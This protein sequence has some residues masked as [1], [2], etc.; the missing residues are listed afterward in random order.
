M[1]GR[2]ALT[3]PPDAVRAY[4]GYGDRPNFP[5]RYNIAPTQPIAI[6]R[7]DE[8]QR[9]FALAR[10][11]FLPAFV[12]DMKTFPLII[13][14]RSEGIA[15]KPS[16][17]SAI[18]RRRCLIPADGFYE[19]RRDG[20]RRLPYLIRRPGGGPLAFA[21]L[22]ETWHTAD[23]SE[24]DTACI[25]TSSA[26]GTISGLHERMPV[27]LEPPDFTPWLDP[28]SDAA[29]VLPLMR[30]AAEDALELV[31]VSS[32]VNSVANEGPDVQHPA[33]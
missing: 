5:P 17:R 12:K 33:V 1:C 25:I 6:V 13:N 20:K 28:H 15:D 9:R 16:F 26:N 14:A 10:W 11:G 30:P 27:I 21:G 22:W 32:A 2:Y 29:V 24:M 19:W 3:L 18:R 23:G 7:L 8:G 4:F 31:A